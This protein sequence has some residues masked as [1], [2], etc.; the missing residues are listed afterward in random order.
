MGLFDSDWQRLHQKIS[1][2]YE[3]IAL[4][5]FESGLSPNRADVIG[6]IT[7]IIR[8]NLPSLSQIELE[9]LIIDKHN[10]FKDFA[11]RD[12][13]THALKQMNPDI[14]EDGVSEIF[15]AVRS[16]FHDPEREHEYFLFLNFR[17]SLRS[18]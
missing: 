5:N 10:S 4:R 14:P 12:T 3:Q 6:I 17:D 18:G 2:Q 1:R 11:V 9:N 15:E 16:R 8:D 7:E 13:I